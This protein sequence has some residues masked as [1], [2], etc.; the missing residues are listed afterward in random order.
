M[1]SAASV[2]APPHG[3]ALA[4]VLTTATTTT[5]DTAPTTNHGVSNT[6]TNDGTNGNANVNGGGNCMGHS[7]TL[8]EKAAAFAEAH[9]FR[10]EAEAHAYREAA[11]RK[12]E[13]GVQKNL[14]SFHKYTYNLS[15]KHP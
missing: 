13:A 5:M 8:N 2:M 10:V 9:R 11:C 6:L 1:S 12:V 4:M 15:R 7:E 14:V 3:S